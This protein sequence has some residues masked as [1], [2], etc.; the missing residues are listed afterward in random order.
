MRC[1]P[2]NE[3]RTAENR[4]A[5]ID[6]VV[7][8]MPPVQRA[9]NTCGYADVPLMPSDPNAGWIAH[10]TAPVPVNVML[11]PDKVKMQFAAA[12]AARW[13]GRRL[14]PCPAWIDK[15]ARPND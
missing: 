9:C 1:P 3:P 15:E 12:D 7:K 4:F 8:D 5:A 11:H 13:Q 10:C 14:R 2:L 6:A